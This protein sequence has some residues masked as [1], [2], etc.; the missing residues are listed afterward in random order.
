MSEELQNESLNSPEVQPEQQVQSG[1]VEQRV[2]SENQVQDT[3]K[4]GEESPV[5]EESPI[6]DGLVYEVVEIN[7]KKYKKFT[8][9]DGT[10]N[11]EPLE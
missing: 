8:N 9:L 7:G 4:K 5:V 3:E 2:E 10:T 1:D 6:E 11:V